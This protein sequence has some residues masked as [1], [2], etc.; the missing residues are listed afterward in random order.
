MKE[1]R[2]LYQ[3]LN[4]KALLP[5][6]VK[7]Y[8]PSLLL[9]GV[10]IEIAKKFGVSVYELTADPAEIAGKPPYIGLISNLGI[11]VWCASAAICIFGAFLT[12]LDRDCSKKWFSFLLVSGCFTA[13]LMLDDFFQIHESYPVLFVGV[14]ANLSVTNPKLQDLFELAVFAVYLA[15]FLFYLAYF[16]KHILRTEYLFFVMVFVCFGFSEVIDMLPESMPFHPVLE[17]GTKFCGI[18]SWFS[19]Y[20]R[21]SYLVLRELIT[22]LVSYP[23]NA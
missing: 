23:D 1:F 12:K 20:A 16:R 10:I 7:I 5:T 17:E 8:L 18:V 6:L 15:F 22:K 3:N 9:I 11:L 19:Y 13:W 2:A 14:N 4:L 21:T